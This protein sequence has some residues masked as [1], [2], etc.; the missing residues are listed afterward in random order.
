MQLPTFNMILKNSSSTDF[1][2]KKKEQEQK[3]TV[4]SI[5]LK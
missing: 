2:L 4:L 3:S 1:P 5:L